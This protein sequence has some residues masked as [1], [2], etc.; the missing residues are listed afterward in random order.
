MNSL[1]LGGKWVGL[2]GQ[3][4][5]IHKTSTSNQKLQ[6]TITFYLFLTKFIVLIF[7]CDPKILI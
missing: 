6:R 4:I 3:I 7:G 1:C 5:D 2:V